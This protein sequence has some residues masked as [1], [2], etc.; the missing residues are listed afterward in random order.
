C[1]PTRA[2]DQDGKQHARDEHVVLDAAACPQPTLADV[3]ED[4][5][6]DVEQQEERDRTRQ[7]AEREERAADELEQAERVPHGG[8]R[9]AQK[10]LLNA[11]RDEDRAGADADEG[12]GVRLE[13]AVERRDERQDRGGAAGLDARH[14]FLPYRPRRMNSSTSRPI[15]SS[16][17]LNWYT[18]DRWLCFSMRVKRGQARSRSQSAERRSAPWVSRSGLSY[19]E[20]TMNVGIGAASFTWLSGERDGYWEG[21]PLK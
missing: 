19:S 12:V 7:D 3:G 2:A 1:V 20:I 9:A 14:A 6:G 8:G 15:A 16:A 11:V 4:D 21:S 17:V 10:Q 18:I 13:R 5:R